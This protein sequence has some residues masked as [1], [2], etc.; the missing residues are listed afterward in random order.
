MKK[1]KCIYYGVL[2][3]LML[4]TLLF[5][6]RMSVFA[7][8]GI[9]VRLYDATSKMNGHDIYVDR[10]IVFD[11]ECVEK[12]SVSFEVSDKNCFEIQNNPGSN[13]SP[14]LPRYVII[15]RDDE[16][17]ATLTV[18]LTTNAGR[19]YST[20][21]TIHKVDAI[22][23]I[24][25]DDIQLF[26]GESVTP[27]INGVKHVNYFKK[28]VESVKLI[29]HLLKYSSSNPDIVSVDENG[30]IKALKGGSTKI[31]VTYNYSYRS[32][33][34]NNEGKYE[35][36][37]VNNPTAVYTVTVYDK[38]TQMSF[39]KSDVTLNKSE[40]YKQ[41]VTVYPVDGV[42]K[43]EYTWVSS[44]K[45][46]VSVDKSGNLKALKA[47]KSVITVF[48]TDGS[49]KSASFSVCVREDK[50]VNV[51]ATNS[52]GCIIVEWQPVSG[53]L[54][55]DLYRASNPNEE[56]IKIATTNGTLYRDSSISYGKN[57]YYKV[58]VISQS[59]NECNSV[60]SDMSLGVKCE[61]E[62]PQITSVKYKKGRCKIKISGAKY[63]GYTLYVVK[64]KQ[65]VAIATINGHT[66][67]LA[68][69]KGQVLYA[70]AFVTV[71]GEKIYSDYSNAKSTGK[72]I[73]KKAKSKTKKHAKKKSKKKSKKK[74][75][76]NKKRK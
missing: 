57:Y 43:K 12:G 47:G 65:K 64:N 14:N 38:I 16:S 51:R 25:V 74:V 62:A 4:M 11:V 41:D 18:K 54:T 31:T 1:Q 39:G 66:A 10:Y 49:E 63:E 3:V 9:S 34:P 5:M 35:T 8:D 72:K 73:V 37:T 71:D 68:L 69:K 27:K 7:D 59:G 15:P 17:D 13:A 58:V 26:T 24:N 36:V 23:S 28:T 33:V 76:K 6:P 60:M 53:A 55:Y 67:N 48:S 61:L 42:T 2:S 44:N 19:V 20:E 45:D 32:M 75:K 56:F 52:S 22:S 70:R 30:N 21:Y 40:T 50:A 29:P 46:I